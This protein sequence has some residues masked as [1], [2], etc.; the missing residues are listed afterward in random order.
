MDPFY[1][2]GIPRIYEFVVTSKIVSQINEW[3]F[4]SIVP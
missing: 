1:K 3:D 4:F 2:L